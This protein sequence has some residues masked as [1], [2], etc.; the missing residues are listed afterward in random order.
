M[1][2]KQIWLS[3]TALES[4]MLQ[5]PIHMINVSLNDQFLRATIIKP[6]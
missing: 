1:Y 4:K 3:V 2:I 5:K 6:G